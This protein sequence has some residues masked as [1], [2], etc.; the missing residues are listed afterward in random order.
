MIVAIESWK[1]GLWKWE[2]ITRNLF[3][4]I[5]VGV[6][7]LPLSMAFAIASGV[8]PEVGIYT[9]VVA[10]LCVSLLGGSRYQIAGP[11]GA[12]VPLLLGILREHGLSGLQLATLMAGIILI[13]M[14]FLKFGRLLKYIPT[15]VLVGFTSGIGTMLFLGQ[16][17]Q[18][19]GLHGDHIAIDYP[20]TFIGLG[21][22]AVIVLSRFA[23]YMCHIPAPLLAL[24][25]GGILQ[26]IFRFP[27]V[28]TIGSEFG[29]IT[30]SFPSL[31]LPTGINWDHCVLLLGPA[32]AIAL[33]G[34]IESLLSAVVADGMTGNKHLANQE[35]IGQGIANIL[36][37][38]FGGIA[39][40][41]A[42]ARTAANVRAGGNSP[43]SGIVAV[44]TLLFILLFCAPL[45]QSI[46]LAALAAILFVISYHMFGFS[47]FIHLLRHAP[48]SDVVILLITY[49]LTVACGLMVAVNV[50]IVL[51]AL[52]LMQRM[53]KAI[54]IDRNKSHE[55][56]ENMEQLAHLPPTVAVY[57]VS[58]PLFFAAM[59]E[60][61]F[62]ISRVD[63]EVTTIILRLG[64]VPFVD[65]TALAHLR[66]IIETF[67]AA[68]QK[69]IFCEAS[70]DVAHKLRRVGIE[71][72]LRDKNPQKTLK[73]AIRYQD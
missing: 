58:G 29:G 57:T 10:C 37:P 17:R 52:A 2:N 3:S 49:A 47:Y 1:A 9:A 5:V 72:S 54:H 66:R 14:G 45:A 16:I 15:Q 33:L 6:I 25:A 8:A 23:P 61:E 69:F 20:T 73:A 11:T 30:S 50:G 36:C 59:E 44:G 53:S 46:P 62:A 24:F 48:V 67:E 28:A 4:G 13:I 71:D 22:L 70:K 18:F 40:T 60:L 41:G 34:A 7:S 35:L 32:F 31:S 12:F 42:I 64:E 27:S 65:T 51:S 63:P 21:C 39:A 56:E 26:A 55:S 43:L 19:F 38:L 68:G